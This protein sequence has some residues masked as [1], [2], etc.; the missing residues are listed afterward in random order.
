MRFCLLSLLALA[1]TASAS[2]YRGLPVSEDTLQT[3]ERLDLPG[4][5][6]QAVGGSPGA[7]A[8]I[9]REIESADASR[10]INEDEEDK[11]NLF[12]LKDEEELIDLIIDYNAEAILGDNENQLKSLMMQRIGGGSL[13]KPNNAKRFMVEFKGMS[14][15]YPQYIRLTR[16][17]KKVMKLRRMIL[18]LHERYTFDDLRAHPTY[19]RL[20]EIYSSLMPMLPDEMLVE[21]YAEENYG[22]EFYSTYFPELQKEE[23]ENE[24]GLGKRDG[25]EKRADFLGVEVTYPQWLRLTNL[26]KKAIKVD[27]M[28]RSVKSRYP[29]KRLEA[30]PRW[31][32]LMRL[33]RDLRKLLPPSYLTSSLL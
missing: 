33:Y 23:N 8:E 18:S 31:G 1:S 19:D 16:L 26:Q 21:D 13:I 17:Q 5:I 2:P 9:I 30:Q 25:V 3:L 12:T 29:L 20:M 7:A 4:E 28:I 10:W 27:Q 22:P 32:N 14:V 6:A 15:T 11:E 24:L